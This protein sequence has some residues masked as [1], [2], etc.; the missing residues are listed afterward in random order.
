MSRGFAI[1]AGGMFCI[2]QALAYQGYMKV[3]YDRLKSD[4]EVSW[5]NLFT[6]IEG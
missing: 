4:V 1:F 2:V 6:Y 3:N 5:L